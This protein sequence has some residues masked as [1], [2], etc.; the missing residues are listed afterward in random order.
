MKNICVSNT[1]IYPIKSLD[2]MELNSVIASNYSL[3]ND[4]RFALFS[5]DAKYINGKRTGRVNQLKTEYDLENNTITLSERESAKKYSF[6][7][8]P[9]NTELLSYLSDFFAMNVSLKESQNGELMDMPQKGS[10]TIMSKASI[11]SIHH[12]FPELTIEDLRSRFRNNIELDNAPAFWEET[13]FGDSTTGIEFKIGDVKM[14]GMKPCARCNVP[15][16]NPLTGETDK[17]FVKRMLESRERSL[18]KGS[19]LHDF[20][21]LYHLTLAA[22]LPKSEVGKV[23]RLGDE[24]KVLG[25]IKL[26]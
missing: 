6:D 23:I 25:P 11:E 7:L 4:R 19:K 17:T 3:L 18:P 2:Y 20:K 12:D 16:R 24:V 13:L 22:Y 10:V 9:N 14:F 8:N 26:K 1:R 21:N 15:P 5:D